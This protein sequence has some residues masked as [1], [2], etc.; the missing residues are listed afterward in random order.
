M[1]RSSARHTSAVLDLRAGTDIKVVSSR[2]G[3]AKVATTYDIYLHTPQDL[4]DEAA[5]RRAA[6]LAHPTRTRKAGS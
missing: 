2:L 4:E 1:I 6:L 5:E 3:H